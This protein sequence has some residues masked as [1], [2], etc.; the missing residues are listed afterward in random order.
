M[1]QLQVTE[2]EKKLQL[3]VEFSEEMYTVSQSLSS[4]VEQDDKYIVIK[5]S[6]SNEEYEMILFS[7]ND[8]LLENQKISSLVTVNKFYSKIQL[9]EKEYSSEL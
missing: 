3:Q 7:S 8:D 1:Q 9:M 2:K 6:N 5:S 4:E